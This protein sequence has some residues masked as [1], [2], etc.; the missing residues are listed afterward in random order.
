[1]SQR[2]LQVINKDQQSNS[3]SIIVQ[4][5]NFPSQKFHAC[6][7]PYLP[8]TSY[9]TDHLKLLCMPSMLFQ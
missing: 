6:P 7:E 1:M 4:A 3:T 8:C 5:L 9:G 2:S